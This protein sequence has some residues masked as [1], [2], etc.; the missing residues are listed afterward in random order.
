[1]F[2]TWLIFEITEIPVCNRGISLLLNRIKYISF[3]YICSL[4][5]IADSSKNY[6]NVIV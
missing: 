5:A 1:M 3:E 2:D 4:S 6:L